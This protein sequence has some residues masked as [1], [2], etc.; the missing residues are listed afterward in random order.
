MYICEKSHF[1]KVYVEKC[2]VLFKLWKKAW[3]NHAQSFLFSSLLLF[4]LP[5]L[6]LPPRTTPIECALCGTSKYV[7]I[8]EWCHRNPKSCQCIAAEFGGDAHVC[9]SSSPGIFVSLWKINSTYYAECNHW[10]A[11]CEKKTLITCAPVYSQ[12]LE[13]LACLFKVWML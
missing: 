3:R 2:N 5:N 8:E 1:S 4:F 12:H 11:P 10:T 9:N 6:P 13:V 7:S